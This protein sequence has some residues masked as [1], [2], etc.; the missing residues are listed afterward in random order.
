MKNSLSNSVRQESRFQL[1]GTNWQEMRGHAR[2]SIMVDYVTAGSLLIF[3]GAGIAFA[4][5]SAFAIAKQSG[6]SMFHHL[7][8][9]G[10]PNTIFQICGALFVISL[11]AYLFNGVEALIDW[12]KH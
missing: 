12:L 10:G 2:D 9:S 7:F 11:M 5:L 8:S 1:Y 6:D 3:F 4:A